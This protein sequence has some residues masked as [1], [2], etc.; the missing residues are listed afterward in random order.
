[1]EANRSFIFILTILVPIQ[2]GNGDENLAEGNGFEMSE[3]KGA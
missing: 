3:I 2:C 1:M